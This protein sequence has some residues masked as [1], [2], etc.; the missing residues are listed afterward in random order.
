MCHHVLNPPLFFQ[1]KEFFGFQLKLP[2]FLKCVDV[3]FHYSS[4]FAHHSACDDSVDARSRQL[5]Q[6]YYQLLA[7]VILVSQSLIKVKFLDISES[8]LK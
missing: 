3:S 7:R 1:Y 5:K 6:S 2:C 8:L 4:F